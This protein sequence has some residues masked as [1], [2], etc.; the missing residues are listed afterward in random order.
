M[1]LVKPGATPPVGLVARLLLDEDEMVRAASAELCRRIGPGCEKAL[2]LAIARAQKWHG[3][4]NV[5]CLAQELELDGALAALLSAARERV[6]PFE[7]LI[8]IK[9]HD[10]DDD[11]RRVVL[12]YDATRPDKSPADRARVLHIIGVASSAE[13]KDL[14]CSALSSPEDVIRRCAVQALGMVAQEEIEGRSG[15]LMCDA[16]PGVR[17]WTRWG[18]WQAIKGIETPAS[19]LGGAMGTS[20]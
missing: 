14:L 7:S 3:L 10:L 5:I 17:A 19:H 1:D 4:R 15:A 12:R 2:R 11:G 6:A 18:G 8:S 13:M 20:P 16:C 9:Y